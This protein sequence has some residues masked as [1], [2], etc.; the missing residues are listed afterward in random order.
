MNCNKSG[1]FLSVS[2]QG[3]CSSCVNHIKIEIQQRLRI[4]GDSHNIIGKSK[5]IEIIISRC[6][7]LIENL[8]EL[9]KYDKYK[10]VEMNF[11]NSAQSYEVLKEE[12][13]LKNLKTSYD[14]IKEK[15]L[16]LSTTNA[17]V[18][19]LNKLKVEVQKYYHLIQRNAGDIN[20]LIIVIDK[21]ISK[22]Q[23]DDFIYKAKKNEFKGNK[24]K[25]L[26]YYYEALYLL[27]TDK[28]E[29]NEQLTQIREVQNKIKELG[30][31]VVDI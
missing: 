30:G 13:I 28:V 23:F 6:D 1:F 25:A 21:E 24:K 8:K 31:E 3:L 15:L 4:I 26:D 2:P 27:K 20:Q 19:Q 7:L 5:N 17:E 9:S 22:V 18:N 10:I 16:T 11:G 12:L 29:D 14:S